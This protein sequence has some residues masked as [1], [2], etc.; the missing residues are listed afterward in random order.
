MAASSSRRFGLSVVMIVTIIFGFVPTRAR[1]ANDIV[2]E[3]GFDIDFSNAFYVSPQGLDTNAGTRGSPFLTI[4]KAIDSA[5]ADG[6]KHT[7]IV[8]N[9][10]YGESVTLA[11]GVSVYGQY[12]SSTWIRDTSANSIING[13][14]PSGSH[15]SA[16][17]ASNITSP[18]MFEHFL[19]VGPGNQNA[20]GDS[21]AIYAS[22]SNA[23]LVIT[24]NIIFGGH[25]GQGLAGTPGSSGSAGVN[26]AANS[27]SLD[28]FTT[29]G[30]GKCDTSNDR[31]ASGGG[32]LTCGADDVSG[33]DGGGN[34]CTPIRSTQDSTSASP[35]TAGQAG[36]AGTSAGA[37]GV[38]GYDS[39]L[40]GTTCYLPIDG[41]TFQVL[42]L[43]GSAG[44]DGDHGNDG[45]GVAGC[46]A[47]GGSVAGDNW[48]G[49]AAPAGNGGID[50][51][52]GGGGAAGGGAACTT[53]GT[54]KDMLGGHGGGGGS[55][56]CAGSGG[57]GGN[58][59]GGAFDIFIVGSGSAPVVTGNLL[60][61][62]NGGDGGNGGS[63]GVGGLG[64]GGGFGG[65]VGALFC[66][67]AGGSGGSGGNGGS[68]SG[69]G[70]GCGGGSYGIYTYGVGTPAYCT[71]ANNTMVG[72]NA[73]FGGAG[74]LSLA[75]PGGAGQDGQLAGC[76]FN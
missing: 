7:V 3:D 44:N 14:A 16:V 39:E 74:G 56:G 46:T 37:A 12:D 68:G 2:F 61:R 20:G 51:A 58:G 8:A 30:T 55:G 59:G 65:Q 15:E 23:N 21:Y 27:G 49:G 54:C 35:A 36:G 63:G 33:G 70:G 4:T 34:N 45:T 5:A 25:G 60:F 75:H 13:V 1:A 42:P 41:N 57:G 73:G 47:P 29:T 38:S 52:G 11:D 76:S 24:R 53:D 19:V 69:G 31:S 22:N 40:S 17:V 43:A 64:G 10:T 71:S 50:G 9:G 32:S 62:G 28:S 72:G 26:G 48:I 6:V 66:T 18:T 67:G